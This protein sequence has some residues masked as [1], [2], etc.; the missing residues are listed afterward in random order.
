MEGPTASAAA[1]LA[2]AVASSVAGYAR[3]TEAAQV[4]HRPRS[5]SQAATGTS[6]HHRSCLR[7]AGHADLPPSCASLPRHESPEPSRQATTFA[8]LPKHAP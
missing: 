5:R 2:A 3:E 8:K 6:S 1:P 7:H 4:R